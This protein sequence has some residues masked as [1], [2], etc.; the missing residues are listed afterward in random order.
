MLARRTAVRVD[1]KR[2]AFTRSSPITSSASAWCSLPNR[3]GTANYQFTFMKITF[4]ISHP[5]ALTVLMLGSFTA[6]IL[7]EEIII[8]DANLNA[9]VRATLQ[10]P[11][12]PLTQLDML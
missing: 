9:V 10:K 3:N 11:N 4:Q 8:P 6:S 12:G 7:A 5:L 2:K 1:V